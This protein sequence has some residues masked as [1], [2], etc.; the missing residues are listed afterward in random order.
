MSDDRQNNVVHLGTGDLAAIGKGL[1]EMY[2]FYLQSKPSE[3][4]ERLVAMIGQN[5]EPKPAEP[6]DLLKLPDVTP[7]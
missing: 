4:I 2:D 5:G 1:R 3:R 6:Q 7:P